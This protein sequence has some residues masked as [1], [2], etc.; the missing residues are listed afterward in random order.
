M[1]PSVLDFRSGSIL[2]SPPVEYLTLITVAGVM[3]VVMSRVALRVFHR[4][5]LNSRVDRR[6]A[7]APV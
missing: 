3:L 5:W 7:A 2:S 4:I 1:P 6:G